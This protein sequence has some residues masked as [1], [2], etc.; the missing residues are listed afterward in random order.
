M[1]R[2]TTLRD[3]ILYMTGLA[4]TFFGIGGIYLSFTQGF[5]G[6]EATIIGLIF[7][8]V[9]T[10]ITGKMRKKYPKDRGKK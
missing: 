3:G 9:G 6:L 8:V 7:L 1:G 10:F 2:A 4:M 5:G